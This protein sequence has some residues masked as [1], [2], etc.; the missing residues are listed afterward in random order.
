MK[1]EKTPQI[2][3]GVMYIR[4]STEEQGKGY[5]PDA[6]RKGIREYAKRNNIKV[7]GEYMDLLSGRTDN[8]PQ[9]QQMIADAEAQKFNTL[10]VFKTSRFARNRSIAIEYKNKLR[11]MGVQVIFTSEDLGENTH[12]P[13]K[14]L[15]EGFYELFDEQ[16]SNQI[17][18]WTREGFNEKRSSGYLLGKPPLGYYRKPGNA[19]DLFIDSQAAVLVREMF[20]QYATGNM[21]LQDVAVKANKAGVTTKLGNPFTYSSV[22]CIL[23]NRGYLGFIPASKPGQQEL[24]GKHEPLIERD[25]FDRV[26]LMF[27]TRAKTKGRPPAKHRFYLLQ[28]IVYCY[29]CFKHIKGKEGAPANTKLLP[30]MYSQTMVYRNGQEHYYYSCK[31]RRENRSCVQKPVRSKIIDDQALAFLGCMKM[32]EKV[33]KRVLE[34]LGHVYD[35]Y[36]TPAMR[37]DKVDELGLLRG[38]LEKLNHMYLHTE[39]ISMDDY[40]KRTAEINNRIKELEEE[41]GIKPKPVNKEQMLKA[42]EVFLR[43]IPAAIASGKLSQEEL[44]AWITLV[45]KRIW[46]KDRKIVAIEPHD[47]YKGLFAVTRKVLTQAPLGTP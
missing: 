30:T 28:G 6:Q 43:S 1:E 32:P 23:Q 42:T 44:R 45:I 35:S 40:D 41:S 21:S 19:K 20:E 7:V 25:L 12:D 5:S 37:G 46:V 8:R 34:R 36:N 2:R 17:S 18:Q 29:R 24:V 3:T 39:S 11:K 26:Q 33:I 22:K 38:K 47:D 27:K 10:L 31:F 9:F 16:L 14:M 4:E 13:N 15:I